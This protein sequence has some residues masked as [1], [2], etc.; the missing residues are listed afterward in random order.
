[1]QVTE[2]SVTYG[3][4]TNLGD[5]STGN[6]EAT[7]TASVSEGEDPKDVLSAMTEL[8]KG[9]V[10]EQVLLMLKAKVAK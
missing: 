1:M 2:I 7:V 8:A 9:A 6:V 3:R 4:K 10:K 5:Y